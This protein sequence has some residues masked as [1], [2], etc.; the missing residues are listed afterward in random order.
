MEFL[1]KT[2]EK[3]ETTITI[4]KF[5]LSQVVMVSMDVGSDIKQSYDHYM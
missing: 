4:C 3:Y 2:Y 5:F 1:K